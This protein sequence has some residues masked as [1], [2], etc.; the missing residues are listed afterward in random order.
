MSQQRV[1]LAMTTPLKL[2]PSRES[3]GGN[4]QGQC[5]VVVWLTSSAMAFFIDLFLV[6][7]FFGG[8]NSYL[9]HFSHRLEPVYGDRL[10]W[11]ICLSVLGYV[12]LS[13]AS[14]ITYCYF[15]ELM[16]EVLDALLSAVIISQNVLDLKRAGANHD[17]SSI[18]VIAG[19]DDDVKAQLLR[20]HIFSS[21]SFTI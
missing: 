11:C 6:F 20:H 2:P 7:L 9:S 8:F 1:M 12:A 16:L 21:W 15:V 5:Y 18:V 4:G 19:V 10:N 3:R 13:S 17:D 14:Q